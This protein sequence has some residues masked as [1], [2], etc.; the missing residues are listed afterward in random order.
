MRILANMDRYVPEEGL[1]KGAVV[2]LGVDELKLRGTIDPFLQI[3]GRRIGD[4]GRQTL[5]WAA[6]GA[7]DKWLRFVARDDLGLVKEELNGLSIDE[8]VRRWRDAIAQAKGTAGKPESFVGDILGRSIVERAPDSLTPLIESLNHDKDGVVRRAIVGLI[9]EIDAY[10]FR[11][12]RTDLGRSAIEAVHKAVVGGAVKLDCPKCDTPAQAWAEISR[13]FFKDDF[14]LSPGSLGA[15]YAQMLHTLYGENT[16]RVAEVGSVIK[17]EWAT[18]EFTDF[19]TYLTDKD[20]FFPS[21]E[22]TFFGPSYSEAFHPQFQAKMARIEDA[23][24][25]FKAGQLTSSK[26]H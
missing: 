2:T 7:D 25:Q 23:W 15:Y 4:Q 24:K 5:Q 14:G 13:Q 19:I 18:P 17:Q 12:R 6:N 10:R 21:W 1:P 22:Y 9:R 8:Q 11:L 3:T 16:I 26:N 20:P